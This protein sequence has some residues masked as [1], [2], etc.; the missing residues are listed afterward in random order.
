LKTGR[1]PRRPAARRSPAPGGRA[2]RSRKAEAEPVRRPPGPT[3]ACLEALIGAISDPSLVVDRRGRILVANES[4]AALTGREP[5][6]LVGL[7][8]FSF[9]ARPE[10]ARSRRKAFA[11]ILRSGKPLV[12]EE[13]RSGRTSVTHLNPVL[14][15]EGKV[16]RVVVVHRDVSQLKQAQARV[17][18]SEALYR[19]IVESAHD[20]VLTLEGMTVTYVNPRLVEMGGYSAEE[21]VGASVP[22]FVHPRELSKILEHIR[23]R[24]QDETYA[25][26]YE[27]I[28]K[29]KRG[30]DLFVEV[31][32]SALPSRPGAP[33]TL[34]ILRDITARKRSEQ[35][36]Q[37]AEEKYRLLVDHSL[38][39]IY[40][41]QGQW[42][43]FCN[44]KFAE[45]FGYGRPGDMIGI[46]IR[47]LVAPE[48]WPLYEAQTRLGES[49]GTPTVHL[50][51]QARR[52]DRS[53][54]E[55]EAFGSRFDYQGQPGI[56][57][58]MIDITARQSA[59][60]ALAET[61]RRLQTLLQAIPDVV[62]FKDDRGRNLAVNKAFE[63]MIGQPQ[64]RIIG[65]T[66]AEIFPADLAAQCR[67]SDAAVLRTLKPVRT[68]ER[69]ASGP[70]EEV[71]YETVKAPIVDDR[72]HLAGMVGVS[73]N[74]TEQK[75]AEKIQSSILRIAQAA[76]SS[77]SL[78]TFFRSIHEIIAGLMPARNFYIAV[79]DEN[80]G[81][82]TFPYFVDEYDP[83]PEPKP[84]GKGLTEYVIRT[85]RP[86]LAKPE[87]FA[88]LEREGEVESIGAPSID[89]L[90]VPL[91]LL[92]RTFGVLVVQSYTE[93]V[94][95]GELERDILQ[96][97]S[98][99][100]AMALHRRRTAEH[101][102]EREQFLSGVLNSIQDGIS[103]LDKDFTILRVNRTM[104][105]RHA[106]AL[107]L[108]GRKCFRAYHRREE[109]CSVCPTRHTLATS[110]AA[111]EV[112][113]RDPEDGGEVEWVD[114][115]SFPF[116]DQASGEMKGVIEY[117]RDI[118]QHKRAE[119]RLQSSLQE[120]EVLLREVHHRVKNN[121]Q[122]I[123]SLI[124]L[125]SR[126]IKDER[127]LEMYKE[128][129]RRIRSMALIHERLYQSADLSRIEFADYL[130]S[131]V[132]HLFHSMIPDT[133]R[134]DLK[135]DLEPVQL[136]VNT[137]I[138]C[139]LIVSELVS[140][141]L[142]HAF[143]GQ[144]RGTVTVS[145]RRGDRGELRLA[146][147]DDGVGLEDGF[148]I[149]KAETLGLQI[150]VTLVSQLDGRLD[151]S[152]EKGAS[153]RVEFRETPAGT[154]A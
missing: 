33:A 105:K 129:Q 14:D 9:L 35:A 101:I 98:G 19:N 97:V 120:K 96:F 93:G 100:V 99:Q 126:R 63:E 108:V 75:R 148:D 54:F 21:L 130:R 147:Q 23:R 122:V 22:Q 31:N 52:R 36:L 62:F 109:P 114:L 83:T 15:R 32:S 48:S 81:L 94:R 133:G 150:V 16:E 59:A 40:I 66:D 2:G 64:E 95:Y 34:V 61:N 142:K 71:C 78:E 112:I 38:A 80:L 49:G 3:D 123:Q 140:N 11:E 5:K 1:V 8:S 47:R 57:G 28:L 4:F 79:Y 149:R 145:F 20:G 44:A 26:K 73:R 104:E 65:R 139:G 72:G 102:S 45:L 51:F 13:T 76:I 60:R 24:E 125:Q 17:K 69:M 143:P 92:D 153:F 117:V 18:E 146:V 56:Q 55:A 53:R 91:T 86:L 115:F 74:I 27:T 137:A 10:A 144:R 134:V 128:S 77:E 7:V 154:E 30:R 127:A 58:M 136:D 25:A 84:L 124:S 118:T 43:K 42:L 151:V 152:R 89:W 37:E 68:E 106:A 121:L 41:T 103:I 138:P 88:R 131:L 111:H 12:T 70:G 29:D 82:L 39:G 85:G 6:A 141:A 46:H 107:P 90:G 50:E 132:A 119:D 113:R 135:M 67:R 87:V 110:Q 116:I